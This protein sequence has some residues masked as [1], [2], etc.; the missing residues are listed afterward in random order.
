MRCEKQ[1]NRRGKNKELVNIIKASEAFSGDHL[2]NPFGY[3]VTLSDVNGQLQAVILVGPV[4]RRH[5]KNLVKYC[6]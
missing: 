2:V 6:F 3:I 5:E 1:L 4:G